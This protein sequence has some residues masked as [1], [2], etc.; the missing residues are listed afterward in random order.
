M[1]ARPSAHRNTQPL[2]VSHH[3]GLHPFQAGAGLRDPFGGYAESDILGAFNAVVAFGNL[4]FQHP[5]KFLPD[6]VKII[7]RLQ[8]VDLVAAPEWERRL[9][10]GKLE[11]QS[12]VKIV[13]KRAPAAENRRLILGACHGIIDVLIFHG[14]CIE[15]A[16][17]LA[18][19]SG[20][21]AR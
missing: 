13:E 5:G 11:R 19:P 18:H 3:I 2:E 6:A 15:P 4:I 17:E 12:A 1:P 21:I 10:K 14:L 7:I 9:I 8:D 20:C 16:G